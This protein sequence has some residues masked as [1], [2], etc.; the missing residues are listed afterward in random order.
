MGG[1]QRPDGGGGGADPGDVGVP[2]AAVASAI[3]LGGELARG[4][5]RAAVGAHGDEGSEIVGIIG[6]RRGADKERKEKK[7]KE[8]KEKEK[9]KD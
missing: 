7:R 4:A 1:G 8:K 3:V 2:R 6:E 9:K 5:G